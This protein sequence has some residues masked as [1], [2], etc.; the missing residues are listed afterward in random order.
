M[1]RTVVTELSGIKYKQMAKDYE[2]GADE[3][4]LHRQYKEKST[5]LFLQLHPI[6]G[7][8]P[9]GLKRA[10]LYSDGQIE[11]QYFP[12]QEPSVIKPV[13]QD[14]LE[15]L[16]S[17]VPTCTLPPLLYL[18]IAMQEVPCD[19]CMQDRSICK[20]LPKK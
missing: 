12:G 14:T 4:D 16:K 5:R 9:R 8:E 11:V 19:R 20:G 6:H 3:F 2:N 18:A 17:L 1:K 7:P 15:R 10:V 13:P